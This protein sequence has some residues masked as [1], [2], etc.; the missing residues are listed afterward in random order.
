MT[1]SIGS[2]ADHC[3]RAGRAAKPSRVVGGRP[4]VWHQEHIRPRRR[5]VPL[6]H[7]L[8]IAR[9]EQCSIACGHR[10]HDGAVVVGCVPPLRPE[11]HQSERAE[12]AMLTRTSATNASA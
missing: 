3:H 5:Q 10:Q 12:A 2:H 7:S 4:V 6:C 8:D 11:D 9:Q 1:E